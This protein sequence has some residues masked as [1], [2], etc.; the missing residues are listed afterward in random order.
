MVKNDSL[1]VNEGNEVA[2]S[3]CFICLQ[4]DKSDEPLM[5]VC[6]C[7]T[8]RVHLSCQAELVRV[9]RSATCRVCNS[10]YRN[11]RCVEEQ[12]RCAGPVVEDNALLMH[13]LFMLFIVPLPLVIAWQRIVLVG[14]D[15]HDGKDVFVLVVYIYLVCT[16]LDALV[17]LCAGRTYRL[18]RMW[19]TRVVTHVVMV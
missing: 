6:R 9:S 10:Q 1:P 14:S 19:E 12:V 8:S 2:S 15:A 13:S 5:Q 4:T 11:V 16:L 18:A 7:V 3:E 17:T